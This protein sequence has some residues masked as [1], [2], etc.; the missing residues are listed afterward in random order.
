[1]KY[2]GYLIDLDGTMFRGEE[3]IAGAKPF[4]DFLNEH[5]LPYLFI[6]NNSTYSIGMIH[7]KLNRLGISTKENQICTSAIATASYIKKENQHARCF[8]I[9]ETVL[10]EAIEDQNLQLTDNDCDY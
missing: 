6:T 7:E 3:R 5:R 10:E 1:M 9:G 2:E 8:V 4:I